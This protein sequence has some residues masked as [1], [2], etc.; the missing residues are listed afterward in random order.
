MRILPAFLALTSMMALAL[1]SGGEESSVGREVKVSVK[2]AATGEPLRQAS[3]YLRKQPHND[4][5]TEMFFGDLKSSDGSYSINVPEGAKTVSIFISAEGHFPNETIWKADKKTDAFEVALEKGQSLSGTVVDPDGKPVSGAV[6]EICMMERLEGKTRKKSYACALTGE[7]GVWRSFYDP[8]KLDDISITVLK[9]EG[10]P[11]PGAYAHLLKA[12][13]SLKSQLLTGGFKTMLRRGVEIK[14]VVTLDDGS[15]AAG[16]TVAQFGKTVCDASGSFSIRVEEFYKKLPLTVSKD[17][18]MTKAVDLNSVSAGQPPLE[19]RLEKGLEI[20]G[21]VVDQDGNPI[22][23]VAISCYGGGVP[24]NLGSEGVISVAAPSSMRRLMDSGADGSFKI[25][26]MPAKG[27]R[28]SFHKEGFST[29]A[30]VLKP[31]MS[32]VIVKLQKLVCISGRVVDAATGADLKGFTAILVTTSNSSGGR[33]SSSS[34]SPRRMDS[35]FSLPLN[36]FENIEASEREYIISIDLDGYKNAFRKGKMLSGENP[37][38]LEFKLEK[39]VKGVDFIECMIERPDGSPAKDACARVSSFIVSENLDSSEKDFLG[40]SGGDGR[41][42]IRRPTEGDMMIN[43][44][45]GGKRKLPLVITH[46]SGMASF[47]DFDALKDGMSIR[48]EKFGSVRGKLPLEGKSSRSLQLNSFIYGEDGKSEC[49]FFLYKNLDSSGSFSFDKVPAGPFVLNLYAAGGQ[50]NYK[51]GVA[52]SGES[53]EVQF[54]PGFDSSH[55]KLL[56]PDFK[57]ERPELRVSAK[58]KSPQGD[59]RRGGQPSS[60]VEDER[61]GMAGEESFPCSASLSGDALT[62]VNVPN[63]GAEF[64]IMVRDGK[65]F[66]EVFTGYVEAGVNTELDLR[67]EKAL[68]EA[69]PPQGP[70]SAPV[71]VR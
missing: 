65:S 40:K 11:A 15:P 57:G 8:E 26:D 28:Y 23:G 27:A 13:P 18:W 38:S 68:L 25:S 6:L 16:A 34:S 42:R 53:V 3:Y 33:R 69:K 32:P 71:P 44:P 45:F 12:D 55:I 29:T 54:N 59:R 62:I 67:E 52:K 22:P 56:L 30:L 58:E 31:D 47:K 2:D 35:P 5:S 41:C 70:P 61:K 24:S 39:A 20:S 14:G 50:Q 60:R 10:V 4:F 49:S 63:D 21:K 66:K 1:S 64:S 17:G 9:A 51:W 7:D 36:S 48:L 19:I 37:P 46:E 43:F